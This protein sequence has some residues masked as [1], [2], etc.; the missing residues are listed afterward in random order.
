[1][2]RGEHRRDHPA[3]AA[4]PAVMRSPRL[5]PDRG[6]TLTEVMFVMALAALVMM[7]LVSFYMTSQAVWMEGSSQAITQRDA[8]LLV[9]AI[10]GSVRR[11]ARAQVEDYNGQ[12]IL[13][14]RADRDPMTDPFRCFYWKVDPDSKIPHVYSGSVTP[15]DDDTLVVVSRVDSLRLATD[16][17]TIVL[18]DL[19]ELPT[20]KG[21]PIRLTS[22][23]A[24]YNR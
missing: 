18:M 20:S 22:A 14:L 7:G 8:T 15:R 4:L 11:A 2:E 13:Y 17:S 12:Q 10:T 1:V 19:I 5:F 24:L 3:H 21:P 23:A 16:D 9:T 6:M